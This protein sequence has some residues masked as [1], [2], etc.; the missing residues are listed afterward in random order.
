MIQQFPDF[1]VDY[2]D[3]LRADEF[4]RE[5]DE[6]VKN[7]TAPGNFRSSRFSTCLTITPEAR[8]PASPRRGPRSQTMISAGPRRRRRLS[9]PLLG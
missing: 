2:P 6:F 5:F 8:G 9:Q 4:L 7:K 1:N 3:Q